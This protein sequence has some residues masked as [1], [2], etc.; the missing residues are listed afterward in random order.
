MTFLSV[1]WQAR[2]LCFFASASI[3]LSSA[4]ADAARPAAASASARVS[5]FIAAS[6]LVDVML[7]IVNVELAGRRDQALVL[8]DV[9]GLEGLVVDHHDGRFLVLAVPYREPH[10]VARPVVLGLHHAP[11]ALLD[12][13]PLGDRQHLVGLRRVLEVEHRHRLADL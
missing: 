4:W 9:L 11:R 8:D 2:Q 5:T 1:W 3:S 13:G 7:R 12:A 10:L 6:L